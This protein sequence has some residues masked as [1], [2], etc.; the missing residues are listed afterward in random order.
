MRRELW[1]T[2]VDTLAALH[3]HDAGEY[4]LRI[5]SATLDLPVEIAFAPTETGLKLLVDL[6]RWRWM[7][8]MQPPPGRMHIHLQAPGARTFVGAPDE[9]TRRQPAD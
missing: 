1:E 3:L 7:D 8:G 4:G 9:R 5:Q 2:L 6:P